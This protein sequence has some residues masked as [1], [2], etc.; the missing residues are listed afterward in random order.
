MK[1]R[2]RLLNWD[3]PLLE[4]ESLRRNLENGK[5]ISFF[6]MEEWCFIILFTTMCFLKVKKIYYVNEESEV[7]LLCH[8]NHYCGVMV[9]LLET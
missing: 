8:T 4:V 3:S 2:I 1:D 9:F 5:K 7:L 6:L